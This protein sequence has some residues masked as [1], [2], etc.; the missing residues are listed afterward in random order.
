MF[1]FIFSPFFWVRPCLS[2]NVLAA[3]SRA[4]ARIQPMPENALRPINGPSENAAQTRAGPRSERHALWIFFHPQRVRAVLDSK[5]GFG[6]NP[7]GSYNMIS[8]VCP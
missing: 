1:R 8:S 3:F 4:A 5:K 7:R 2:V 6:E